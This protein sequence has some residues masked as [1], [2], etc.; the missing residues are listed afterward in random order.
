MEALAEA[1]ETLAAFPYR[2]RSDFA[3]ET[4][5]D[6]GVGRTGPAGTPHAAFYRPYN[7]VKLAFAKVAKWTLNPNRAAGVVGGRSS[8]SV[9][10]ANT[11]KT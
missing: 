7:A 5:A 6:G 11:V 4:P 10:K 9:F 1:R 8:F 3:K 2:G